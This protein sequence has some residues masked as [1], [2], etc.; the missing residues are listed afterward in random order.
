VAVADLSFVEWN[1]WM[2]QMRQWR[3]WQCVAAAQ[4]AGASV[5]VA[6]GDAPAAG[7][8]Q[9]EC[10]PYAPLS[11]VPTTTS[12]GTGTGKSV[13]AVP[14]ELLPA[15][16]QHIQAAESPNATELAAE[17]AARSQSGEAAAGEPDQAGREEAP[18]RR[19]VGGAAVLCE[20]AAPLSRQ[21]GL[22]RRQ[23]GCRCPTCGSAGG[24][25][26][27]GRKR[28]SSLV[29]RSVLYR[30]GGKRLSRAVQRTRRRRSVGGHTPVGLASGG[31]RYHR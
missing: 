31:G 21:Q 12:D 20:P 18:A 27:G 14:P 11:F 7:H 13:E 5:A 16:A 29:G 17:G 26:C 6:A 23:P 15:L 24:L 28:R 30:A 22:V 10:S 25:R 9:L 2:S 19:R 3:Q 1:S 4:G 8:E